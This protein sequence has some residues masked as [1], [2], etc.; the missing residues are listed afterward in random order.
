MWYY[1][2]DALGRRI[3]KECPQHHLR[4]EYLCYGDQLAYA[5]T[6]KNAKHD[7]L[8]HSV[9]NGWQLLAQQDSYQ[10]IK[11]TIDGNL[12]EWRLE[13]GYAVC[14][15]NGQVLAL[16]NPKGR[17]LWR[18]EKQT[19]WGLCFANEYKQPT[20]LDPQMLFAGQWVDE[21]SGLAYKLPLLPQADRL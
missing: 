18:K 20:P 12:V 8:H 10:Q 17:T 16:L 19:L 5:Q 7:R 3:S 11:Q 9:F 14:Q 15:P 6:F 21:E 4:I 2:Y 1:K 13:T